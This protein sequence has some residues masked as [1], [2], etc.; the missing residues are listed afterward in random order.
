[1]L[2]VVAF[3]HPDNDG[4]VVSTAFIQQ[5]G[6][7]GWLITGTNISYLEYGDSLTGFCQL[8]AAI[9]SNTESSCK[10]INFWTSPSI[11]LLNL[12]NIFVVNVKVIYHL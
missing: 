10:A 4:W 8:I 7:N 1:L 9:H 6:S 3:V 11:P 12:G 5:L 2:I